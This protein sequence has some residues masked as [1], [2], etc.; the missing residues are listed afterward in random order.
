MKISVLLE[1]ANEEL[2]DGPRRQFIVPEGVASKLGIGAGDL[3]ELVTGRGSPLRAWAR[4]GGSGETVVVSPSSLDI[5]DVTP[6]D[7]VQ[8]RAA[9]PQP[10]IYG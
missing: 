6:G 2:T 8:I 5:L 4:F 10:E 1:L 3:I 7:R 9:R